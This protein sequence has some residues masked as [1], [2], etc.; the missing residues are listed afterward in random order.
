[1]P[2]VRNSEHS[3]TYQGSRPA[4]IAPD[5][6]KNRNVEIK[7]QLTKGIRDGESQQNNGLR[8]GRW[9]S[10][11]PLRLEPGQRKC[12]PEAPRREPGR[13]MDGAH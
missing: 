2:P 8:A 12:S 9:P 5:R 7:F 13:A 1:M 6:R 11:L 3:G 4:Y 10:T